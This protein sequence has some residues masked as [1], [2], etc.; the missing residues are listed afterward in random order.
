MR[1]LVTGGSGFI[2]SHVVDRLVA[3]GHEPRI[4]DVRPPADHPHL[5]AVT[6]DLLDLDGLVRSM[7]GCD[8]VV[9]LAAAADVDDVA[10]RPV[11]AESV[12]A[13]GTLHVLEAARRAG[14]GRV[15]YAS[16]IWVYGNGAGGTVDE[17]SAPG[18]PSH[19]YTATK[20]AGE[21]Y[22]R[23]YAELFGLTYTILRFGIPFGP[24]ARPAGVIP[25]FVRKAM[26]GEALTIAGEGV[27]SRRF[28]YV[29]DLAEGVVCG[30][31][32]VA[33]NRV[34]N[35][36]G[37]ESVSVRGIADTV[38]ELV[39]GVDIVHTPARA[40]DFAGIEVSGERAERELG[41]R[42]TTPF[43][44]GVERYIAWH[45]AENANGAAEP[46]GRPVV[47][48]PALRRRLLSWGFI[49]GT[50]VAI[51]GV[52]AAYL[53]AVHAVGVDASDDRTVGAMTVSGLFAYFALVFGSGPRWRAFACWALSAA[54]AVTIAMPEL[55]EAGVMGEPNPPLVLL[56]LAGG[57]LCIGLAAAGRR[58]LGE[59][60]R[61]LL[62]DGGS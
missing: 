39:G 24:R 27:Q 16:T 17:E 40:G 44:Q 48:R 38:R 10:R 8:A 23:A 50:L 51:V 62:T 53:D 20:L 2:G 36:V 42:A 19:L 34:Y 21:H 55:R 3:A 33:A 12:N 58:M 59:D 7:D 28:V 22:C 57:A 11:E 56:G 9:H 35:L 15:V 37:D 5:D 60:A 45:E 6:G 41:W 13:R 46:A 32:P 52:L 61:R 43:R 54:C 26:A 30:L 47:A 18:A 29:E 49:V 1:V 4:F 25:I 14:V 31:D